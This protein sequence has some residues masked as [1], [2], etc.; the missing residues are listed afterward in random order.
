MQKRLLEKWMVWICMEAELKLKLLKSLR[1]RYVVN[2]EISEVDMMIDRI[3]EDLVHTAE[4]DTLHLVVVLILVIIIL[5]VIAVHVLIDVILVVTL[6]LVIIALL[7]MIALVLLEIT[8][9]VLL[10]ITV[11]AE[12]EIINHYVVVHHV[13]LAL[14]LIQEIIPVLVVNKV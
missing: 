6:V 7:V 14:L 13:I 1:E 11:I 12:T 2:V 4:E 3:V 5:H 10:P 8:P 9:V